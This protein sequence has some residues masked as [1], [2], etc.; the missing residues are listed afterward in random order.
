LKIKDDFNNEVMNLKTEKTSLIQELNKR[1]VELDKIN[2][3]KRDLSSKLIIQI[4]FIRDLQGCLGT[5]DN[6]NI[7]D[8]IDKDIESKFRETK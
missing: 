5:T 1:L 4:R 6:G 7:H 3:E 8:I 2:E